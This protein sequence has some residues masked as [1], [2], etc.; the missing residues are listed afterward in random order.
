MQVSAIGRMGLHLA[1]GRTME[2][3][4]FGHTG[5]D[6]VVATRLTLLT[7]SS[8]VETDTA[9]DDSS[10]AGQVWENPRMER[11]LGWVSLFASVST[12]ICCALTSFLLGIRKHF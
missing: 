5:L 6:S 11:G 7:M 1:P 2:T 4:G 10:L 9:V 12:W 8:I 3:A